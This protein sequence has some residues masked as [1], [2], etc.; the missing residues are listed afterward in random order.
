MNK[1]IKEFKEKKE[2]L[3]V[4]LSNYEVSSTWEPKIEKSTLPTGN[5]LNALVLEY[6]Q[7]QKD[8]KNFDEQIQTE[9]N[10]NINSEGEY[11]GS[12][13]TELKTQKDEKQQKLEEIVKKIEGRHSEQQSILQDNE[14]EYLIRILLKDKFV[15]KQGI[16]VLMSSSFPKVFNMYSELSKASFEKIHEKLDKYY[17]FFGKFKDLTISGFTGQDVS[18]AF[19]LFNS[20]LKPESKIN[21]ATK[22]SVSVFLNK[23]RNII[24]NALINLELAKEDLK[25]PTEE[26]RSIV[27]QALVTGESIPWKTIKRGLTKI[28]ISHLFTKTDKQKL[29]VLIKNFKERIFDKLQQVKVKYGPLGLSSIDIKFKQSIEDYFNEIKGL[30]LTEMNESINVYNSWSIET[31]VNEKKK[32][33]NDLK[34]K[35]EQIKIYARILMSLI[36]KDDPLYNLLNDILDSS[37]YAKDLKGGAKLNSENYSQNFRLIGEELGKPNS[38]RK[39]N[40]EGDKILNDQIVFLFDILIRKSIK[41]NELIEKGISNKIILN[42]I[43]N[44]IK[45]SLIIK[46]LLWKLKDLQTT[47]KQREQIEVGLT[48]I[49]ER[50]NDLTKLKEIITKIINTSEVKAYTQPEFRGP[51]GEEQKPEFRGPGN[52]QAIPKSL[53]TKLLEKLKSLGSSFSK[54]KTLFSNIKFPSNLFVKLLEWFKKLFPL[55]SKQEIELS[56]QTLKE[57]PTTAIK[58]I[59]NE[60]DNDKKYIQI[61]INVFIEIPYS[62]EKLQELNDKELSLLFQTLTKSA[63]DIE[64]LSSTPDNLE[65]KREYENLL[66]IVSSKGLEKNIPTTGG[67]NKI[68]EQLPIE[69]ER[70]NPNRAKLSDL[71]DQIN[72]VRTI[73]NKIQE[74][75]PGVYSKNKTEKNIAEPPAPQP[76]APEPPAPEPPA[77]EPPAPQPPAPPPLAEPLQVGDFVKLKDRT[78]HIGKCLARKTTFRREQLSGKITEI[79]ENDAKV[80]CYSRNIGTGG[81]LREIQEREIE[82]YAL[83]NL[84]KT[85]GQIPI[86]QQGGYTRRQG[87]LSNP[88]RR[89]TRRT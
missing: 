20:L 13:Y 41:L 79:I 10:N 34:N 16:K 72:K 77:P 58:T 65:L 4:D 12:K 73:L 63:S 23:N 2:L 44:L 14:F 47:E 87:F 64:Q 35:L 66:V 15:E 51:E 54:L 78:T 42:N 11:T 26:T 46:D 71:F 57:E 81:E 59:E 89:K 36:Q 38:E 55:F 3:L 75:Y 25:L 24:T 70:N 9:I 56:S 7:I 85:E 86:N 21:Q 8:V 19:L 62:I 30:M 53:K 69:P 88:S 74:K 76:P 5:E 17:N 22:D 6:K 50:I 27:E 49:N 29:E 28:D 83:V 18:K 60:N 45:E 31:D 43:N 40:L 33:S 1:Q 84:V 80:Q 48:D 39:F 67:D 52:E 61:L 82:L 32:K 37:E 68:Q